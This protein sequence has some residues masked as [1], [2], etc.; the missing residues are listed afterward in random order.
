MKLLRKNYDL[1][2]EKL[3][4]GE[5][6]IR[7]PEALLTPIRFPSARLQPLGHLSILYFSNIIKYLK[8]S[9]VFHNCLF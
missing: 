4:G 9:M 2:I 8:M 7:T 1:P 5:R 3:N 6:G